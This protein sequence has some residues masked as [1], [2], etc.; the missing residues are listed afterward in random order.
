MLKKIKKPILICLIPAIFI[1][2]MSLLSYIFEFVSESDFMAVM[3]GILFLCALF[4]FNHAIVLI[5]KKEFK[6]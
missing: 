3:V 5:Y 6:K 2:D 4:Y 1:L